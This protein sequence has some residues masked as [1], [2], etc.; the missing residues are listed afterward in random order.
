MFST[1]YHYVDVSH[2]VAITLQ[3]RCDN[4][5]T[6]SSHVGPNDLPD[7]DDIYDCPYYSIHHSILGYYSRLN[8]RTCRKV[9][10]VL[11]YEYTCTSK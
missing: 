8:Q 9:C 7:C 10:G 3:S 2:N 1:S 4:Y 11:N 5:F 6:C